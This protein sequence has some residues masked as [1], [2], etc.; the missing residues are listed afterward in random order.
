MRS[1]TLAHQFSVLKAADILQTDG[2]DIVRISTPGEDRVS[3][4]AVRDHRTGE[5]TE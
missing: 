5:Y 3:K 1:V 4:T 2:I